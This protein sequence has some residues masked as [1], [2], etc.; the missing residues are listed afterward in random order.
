MDHHLYTLDLKEGEYNYFIFSTVPN[1]C[2]IYFHPNCKNT[3]QSSQRGWK[4]LS[5]NISIGY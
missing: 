5:K 3:L 2:L 1:P 4:K